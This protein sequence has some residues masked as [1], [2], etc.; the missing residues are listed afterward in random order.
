MAWVDLIKM[1]MMITIRKKNTTTIV[2]LV[3]FPL[4][5]VPISS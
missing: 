3:T 1:M 5:R 2:T 4:S